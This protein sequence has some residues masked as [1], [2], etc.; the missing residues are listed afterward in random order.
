MLAAQ[1]EE[2]RAELVFLRSM[3]PRGPTQPAGVASETT[4]PTDDETLGAGGSQGVA[5]APMAD[6][7]TAGTVECEVR[8]GA[9]DAEGCGMD[10]SDGFEVYERTA[11]SGAGGPHCGRSD[12]GCCYFCWHR[13]ASGDCPSRCRHGH[14]R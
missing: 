12:P 1:I 10:A 7:D 8:A 9:R 6:T 13:P 11:A 2:R 5:Q 14:R 3:W 4:T